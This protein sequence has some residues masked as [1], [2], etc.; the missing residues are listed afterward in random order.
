MPCEGRWERFDTQRKRAP[1]QDRPSQAPPRAAK[2]SAWPTPPYRGRGEWALPLCKSGRRPKPSSQ[3]LADLRGSSFQRSRVVKNV[4][5]VHDEPRFNQTLLEMKGWADCLLAAIITLT[6][7]VVIGRLIDF[8]T[9]RTSAAVVQRWMQV[10]SGRR[11]STRR[12]EFA[13]SGPRAISSE[14][15]V[16]MVFRSRRW[17][18]RR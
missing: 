17:S 5:E 10:F 1:N 15:E 12:T 8:D 18:D 11:R 3:S 4:N 7:R 13:N 14:L 16:S 9:E 2:N 6:L